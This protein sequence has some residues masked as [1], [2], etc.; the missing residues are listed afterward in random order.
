[1]H[2]QKKKVSL[3]LRESVVVLVGVFNVAVLAL[4][5]G[6]SGRAMEVVRQ[7]VDSVNASRLA[8]IFGQWRQGFIT[9]VRAVSAENCPAGYQSLAGLTWNGTEPGCRCT[10]RY[11][12]Y[13]EVYALPGACP[14]QLLNLGCT[15]IDPLPALDL[16]WWR[17][18][19]LCYFRETQLTYH[20][21]S[22]LNC[23]KPCGA[24]PFR[25]CVPP[26]AS[27]PLTSLRNSSTANSSLVQGQANSLSVVTSEGSPITAGRVT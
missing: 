11:N 23:T 27:C 5:L 17:D 24:G 2:M 12:R 13:E 20:N 6:Y 15:G 21:T 22:W 16:G 8:Q 9:D 18:S 25:V 14:L 10:L 3:C 7:E 26:N 1:M 4:L 19:K